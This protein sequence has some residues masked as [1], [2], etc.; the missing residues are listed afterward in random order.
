GGGSFGTGPKWQPETTPQLRL[1]R[2]EDEGK[3]WKEDG[4]VGSERTEFGRVWVT[5]DKS[6]ILEGACKRSK[7]GCPEGPPLIRV[8]GAKTFAKI[9]VPK[10]ITR[11]SEIAFSPSGAKAYALARGYSGPLTLVV[12]TNGGK[13]FTRTPL[14]ALAS[15]DAKKEPLSPQR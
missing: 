10:G 11:V 13:D 15:A 4:T 5:A 14:P 1:Y 8:Q 2:S 12:S 7:Y 6:L 9:G 3:T